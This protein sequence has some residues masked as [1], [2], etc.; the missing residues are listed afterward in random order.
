MSIFDQ[1]KPYLDPDIFDQNQIVK[2][3][4]K[5]FILNVLKEIFPPELLYR[6]IM[7]GSNT[8]YQ[9]ASDSDIDVN[10]Q[11]APGETAD[12]WHPIF[13]EFN[14]LNHLLPGTDHP[15]NF[16]FQEYVA[17]DDEGYLKGPDGPAAPNVN[18]EQFTWRNSLGA[19]DL[20][21]NTWLKRPKPFNE[22][23]DPNV[24][25]AVEIAYVQMLMQMV[26][27]EIDAVKQAIAVGDR[28]RALM[29][30]RDLQIFFHKVDDD[31]KT[32]FK[33]GTG[34]SPSLEDYNLVYKLFEHSVYGKFL[35]DLIG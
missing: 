23:G 3:E 33:Y 24:T 13:K 5:Q 26:Q 10:V 12:K 25:Y 21:A 6:L 30:L 32:T 8:T 1:P 17:P 20:L 31:R 15:V 2:P 29:G 4:V 7:I 11:G 9:Y 18:E 35:Q 28:A 34:F 22:I 27:S 14:N 19:Y 16:Y